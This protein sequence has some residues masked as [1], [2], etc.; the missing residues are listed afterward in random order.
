MKGLSETHGPDKTSVLNS[1]SAKQPTASLFVSE[2]SWLSEDK[3]YPNCD[4][5]AIGYDSV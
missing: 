3:G 4:Y 1:L 5:T 2:I